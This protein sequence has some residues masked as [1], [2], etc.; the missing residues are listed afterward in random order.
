[1]TFLVSITDCFL[2]KQPNL[3]Y[4][5]VTETMHNYAGW[6]RYAFSIVI[7]GKSKIYIFLIQLCL[8]K[9]LVELIMQEGGKCEQIL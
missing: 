4:Q 2:P 7:L 8:Q 5:G 6:V 9:N 3:N 1:M